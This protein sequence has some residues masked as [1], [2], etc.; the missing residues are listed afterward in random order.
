MI[1]PP[2]CFTRV[3]PARQDVVER[4]ERR[5]ERAHVMRF[6]ADVELQAE[7]LL[8]RLDHRDVLGHTTGERHLLLD[9]RPGAAARRSGTAIDWC[10]PHRMSSIFLPLP[11]HASTSDSAKDRAGRAD[12]T[13]FWRVQRRRA[14]DRPSG[15]SSAAAA[16]P[17]KR[18]VPAAHLSFMQKSTISP[19]GLDAN[20]LGVLALPCPRPSA[21]VGEH[22]HG[23]AP[24]AADLGDLRVA[25]G[26]PV[27]AV[28]GADDVL[29]FLL[30]GCRRRRRALAKDVS[31]APGRRW[32]PCR[33]A[34]GRRS[35]RSS[36]MMTAL[37]CVDPTSTPAAYAMGHLSSPVMPGLLPARDQTLEEGVDPVLHLRL[38]H[39]PPIHHVG[40]DEEAGNRRS[41]PDN[42]GRRRGRSRRCGSS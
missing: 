30:A 35:V 38:G 7:L 42:A 33:S 6:L 25:E 24:V 34:R 16:A 26:H 39:H 8:D 36:S 5:A 12:P 19:E 14:R 4:E 10:T 32:R 28:A 13:G 23:A 40:L 3:A 2:T 37:V 11:S 31:A 15:M 18:P 20:G 17:R 22:V 9:A 1:L 29:D 41:S 27:A 21:C